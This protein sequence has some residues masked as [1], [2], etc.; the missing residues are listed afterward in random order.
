[1]HIC[2]VFDAIIDRYDVYKVETIGDA[3]MVVSGLPKKIEN[4]AEEISKMA[5]DLRRAT[6]DLHIP[7]CT[8]KTFRL[9][10]GIHTGII[11]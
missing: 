6:S 5:I 2:S 4:H 1:M 8:D 7:Q 3:Y 10:I 11:I 9:R